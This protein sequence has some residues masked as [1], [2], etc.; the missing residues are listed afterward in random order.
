MRSSI[1]DFLRNAQGFAV[2]ALGGRVIF[3]VLFR[4]CQIVQ[5]DGDI[6]AFGGDGAKDFQRFAVGG[7]GGGVVF[8]QF[9]TDVRAV[10]WQSLCCVVCCPASVRRRGRRTPALRRVGCGE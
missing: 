10:G 1:L 6:V 9:V 2:V 8:V 3:V 4:V 5:C 7:D